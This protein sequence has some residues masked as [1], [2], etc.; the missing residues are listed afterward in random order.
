MIEMTPL[1]ARI[2]AAVG[3]LRA[4]LDARDARAAPDPDLAG[5][6][7]RV[8][9]LEAEN[10]ELRDELER[11]RVK[12]DRDVAALDELIAQLKPLIEEV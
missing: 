6:E 10:A 1:D 11:L 12:R 4:A 5:L 3:R 8:G 7:A 2:A 9:E